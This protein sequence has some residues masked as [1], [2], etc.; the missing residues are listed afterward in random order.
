[1]QTVPFHRK[2]IAV[3]AAVLLLHVGG[4]LALQSGL[5]VRAYEL[6]VPVEMIS[7]IITPPQPEVAPPPPPAPPPPAPAQPSRKEALP[8]APQPLAINDPTPVPHA[9]LVTPTP[10]AALPPIAAP[11]AAAPS[12]APAAPAA[13]PAPK[14]EPPR[15]DLDYLSNPSPPYPRTSR[16]LGEQGRVLVRVCV[17][18]K[19]QPLRAEVSKSSS[20]E[21]L[22]AAAVTAVMRWRFKPGSRNGVPEPGCVGVPVDFKLD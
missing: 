4:L 7:Q 3:A 6:V 16:N 21:R 18:E 1:M 9:P 11:V 17:D 5:L 19:G 2:P 8:P 20:Y 13:P 15:S 14:I 22:D 12:P 10:P